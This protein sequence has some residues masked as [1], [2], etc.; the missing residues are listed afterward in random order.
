MWFLLLV[1]DGL[2]LYR[3]K[4]GIPALTCFEPASLE[5]MTAADLPSSVVLTANETLN[6]I[7]GYSLKYFLSQGAKID[8]GCSGNMLRKLAEEVR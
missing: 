7:R 8:A 3:R 1:Y 2:N 4:A 5:N 6:Y